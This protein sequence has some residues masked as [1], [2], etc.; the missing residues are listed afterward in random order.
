MRAIISAGVLALGSALSAHAANFSLIKEYSGQTF[1]D[2]WQFY[3]DTAAGLNPMTGP[4]NG[5]VPFDDLNNG[6]QIAASK[7]LHVLMRM[8]CR[9]RLLH[10]QS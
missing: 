10:G 5:R 7:V 3:G 4:W 8:Y 6:T 9:R 2:D 1:F